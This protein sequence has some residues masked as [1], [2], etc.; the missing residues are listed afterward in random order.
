MRLETRRRPVT[1]LLLLLS[2]APAAL[3]ADATPIFVSGQD[4]AYEAL[5]ADRPAVVTVRGPGELRIVTRA[6]F[7]PTMEDGLRYSLR[8]RVDGGEEMEVVYDDVQRSRTAMF[9]DGTLGVPGRLM[10]HRIPLRRGYHNVEILPGPGAPEIFFR[11]LF[12]PTRERRR[13]WVAVSPLESPEL[14]ELVVREGLVA[15]HRNPPGEP[16]HVEVIGPTELRI[17]TRTEN[18]PEMR[19]RIHYRLQVREG[20]TV[21]NTFQLSSRRSE[22]TTYLS[23]DTLVPGRAAEIVIPIPAGAHRLQILPLDPDKSTLLA[24]FMLPREDLGLTVELPNDR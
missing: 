1:L 12:E 6:R 9:R 10:D 15:Y 14:V 5:D 24:R 4:R 16:F 8:V 13:S 22:I 18:S 11:T 7:R 20:E 23:D 17:F 2:L 3:R 21:I 19:G